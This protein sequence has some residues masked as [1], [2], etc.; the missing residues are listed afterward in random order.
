MEGRTVV[1]ERWGSGP[2]VYLM[3]GW[4]GWRGQ[5]SA[6]V[7]GLV[8]AGYR[9]VALDAP[10][11]GDSDPGSYG[12]GRGLL[13]EF[14]AALAA[15]TRVGGPAYAVVGHSLGGAAT[16]LAVLD[17]LPAERLVLVAPM[18]DPIAY[19]TVFARTLGFGER[20]RTGFL[21][22]LERRVGRPMSDFDIP[23]RAAGRTGLPPMLVVHD[24]ADR[25]VR[26]ADAEAIVAAWPGAEGRWTDGLGH[27]RILRDPATVDAVVAYLSRAR[28]PQPR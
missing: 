13:P 4:G 11:H 3:H 28:V 14:M 7:P 16:A 15:V 27:R 20:I 6:F 18:A 23:A 12:P 17:G 21:T 22:R 9:V 8:A 5:F 26:Y 24:R 19:T 10:S 1:A 25:E 2:T